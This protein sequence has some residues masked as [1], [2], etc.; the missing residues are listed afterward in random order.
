MKKRLRGS[1]IIDYGQ[2]EVFGLDNSNGIPILCDSIMQK[3]PECTLLL[4]EYLKTCGEDKIMLGVHVM[5]K[6]ALSNRAE[7][8]ARFLLDCVEAK[9]LPVDESFRILANCLFPLIAEFP[10]L[11]NR[12]IKND[13]FSFEYG[14]FSV[15]RSL[16]DKNK[17]RPIAMITEE[18]PGGFTMTDTETVRDFWIEKCVEHSEDLKEDSTDF[19]VEMAAKFFCVKDPAILTADDLRGEHLCVCLDRQDFPVEF[20]ESEALKNLVDWWFCYH[21]QLYYFFIFLDGIATLIFTIFAYMY[22]HQDSVGI[23]NQQLLL[24]LSIS[25]MILRYGSLFFYWSFARREIV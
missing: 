24:G 2:G 11:A 10:D 22:G 14:R 18:P 19:Q 5:L 3:H 15:S 21:C 8:V 16:I 20:F 9:R 12:Y 4:L 13:S 17:N 6:W 1:L 23:A 7:E 25:S